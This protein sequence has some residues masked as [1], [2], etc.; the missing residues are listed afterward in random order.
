MGVVY[1]AVHP[2]LDVPVAV[3]MLSE[4]YSRDE[5]F[6]QRFQREAAMI[7]SLNHPGIVRVYD[8][9]SDQGSLFIVMEYVEGRTLRS[10]LGEYGRFTVEVADDLTQQLLSAVGAAH[11]KG[12]VHRDLKPDNVLIST[13]GK[14]KILDFGISKVL[15]D[16]RNLT[17]TGSMVGTPSYMSP[18][19]VKGE[20]VDAR[21]DIYALG[22]IL[23]ELLHGEP[24]YT[25]SMASVLHAHVYE[26]ARPSTAI[27]RPIMEV[28]WRAMAKDKAQRFQS[29]EEFSG[30]LLSARQ[31]AAVAPPPEAPPPQQAGGAA[32]GGLRLKLPRIALP[33][34]PRGPEAPTG[35][36]AHGHCAA[37][38]GWQCSYTD[39]TGE[40]CQAWLCKKH[41]SFLDATPFCPRHAAVVRA[42]AATAGTIRE[43]KHRPLVADRSL[44]LAAMVC[45]DVNRDLTELLRRRYQNRKD[46]RITIDPVLR[47]TWEGRGEVAWER[48]WAAVQNQGYMARVGVRVA[49]AAP[50][51]VKVTIGN[52]TILEEVPEWIA[53][54]QFEGEAVD[55]GERARFRNRIVEAVLQHID[56]PLAMPGTRAP[57]AK[58]PVSA[59]TQ[60]ASIKAP[61]LSRTLLEGMVL[62]ALSTATRLTGWEIADQ[63]A[64]PHTTVEAALQGLAS[65]NFI[66]PMGL[67]TS[68]AGSGRP[69]GERMAYSLTR[70]GRT[71]SD[72]IGSAGTRYV[73]AA[74]VSLEEYRASVEAVSQP[75]AL[76][77]AKVAAA[78]DGLE[79]APGVAEAV[80]A[81]VN[82]R[83]SLFIYGS[84]GNGKTS[85]ARRMA[86]MLGGPILVPI[87]IDAAG[88]VIRVFDPSVHALEG[89]PPADARWKRVRRPLVQ[90]GGEF[91]LAM[92]DPTWEEGSRTYQAPVQIKANGG[93]LLIDDLGRQKFSPKQ[94][95]DRLMVPL[96]QS[97]DYLNL[98]TTGRK[99]EL[100][101]RTLLA[102]S[103]NL[104]PADLLDEAYLRRLSYKVL[105]P[106][107]TWEAWC[108]IFDR[109]RLRLGM[110][111]QP[112]ALE[113]I[114][115]LYG[116]RPLRGNHPRDLLERLVDVASARGVTPQLTPDL[117]QAAWKTL[118]VSA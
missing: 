71:R 76:D 103:T 44:P 45:E 99:A 40:Q 21:A 29:C 52:T 111:P 23:Y 79:L 110:A 116:G 61:E 11:A 96:E 101:F 30:A 12:I 83:G 8:F 117:V 63:L 109:E 25:G 33:G 106:D 97:T 28:I 100:P 14:T 104:S 47:Q 73:G 39:P 6:R 54:R 66:E 58:D 56:Q 88:E 92:L 3:K 43:I 26:T 95:L 85:L 27:P 10:W 49:A 107:P 31:P 115:A 34:A 90:V 65:G 84:P 2:G 15:D 35:A 86:A 93:V 91:D 17:A 48:S 18:E 82:S 1:R 13:Q 113:M 22:V 38:E 105:M 69:I 114:R 32:P 89:E 5:S 36:C 50:D 87:A 75:V 68:P 4:S 74:P 80:R 118:F 24:P 55:H 60:I 67:D 77:P 102:L 7:A 112:Q 57:Q 72:E 62:R 64:V 20:E 51:V 41:I 46:L 53:K 19:Q 98:A 59:S 94:L 9:D 78:L 108:R 70:Q 81:A 16:S 42:L 37:T